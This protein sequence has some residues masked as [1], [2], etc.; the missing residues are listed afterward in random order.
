M[1]LWVNSLAK[2]MIYFLTSGGSKVVTNGMG[3]LVGDT[4]I[5]A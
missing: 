1:D 4:K 5:Q 2:Q 3:A